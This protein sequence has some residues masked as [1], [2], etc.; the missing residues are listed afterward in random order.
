[1]R[2]HVVGVILFAL[3]KAGEAFRFTV[4]PSRP[5][6]RSGTTTH[7]F[8]TCPSRRDC[9]R[10]TVG[11]LSGTFITGLAMPGV[12]VALAKDELFRPNPL[13]NKALE[14]LRI[15]EQAEADELKYGG[16][17]EA[18]DA[19]PTTTDAYSQLLV[20][21]V[22]I[23]MDLQQIEKLVGFPAAA[24]TTSTTINN[25]EAWKQA[26]TILSQPVYD[27]VKFKKIFNRYG[28]NIYYNDPDRAN[29]YL[30]GGATPKN[31]QSLAYLLRNEILTSIEDMV[32]EL[33]YLIKNPTESPEDLQSMIRTA[34][35][36]M[37]RY[38]AVVPPQELEQA[39]KLLSKETSS[40]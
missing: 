38:L 40:F 23:S 7:L 20:P 18:G 24:D 15:L 21:I 36:A 28:D 39:Q 26:R 22:K 10:L 11:V 37:Q 5:S 34:C 16:E 1:M 14:K 33:D 27:K 3:S 13:T 19:K 4:A 17:L 8:Q 9:I 35:N 32:A 30:G 12:N 2:I 31:E 6:Q 29:V 25:M